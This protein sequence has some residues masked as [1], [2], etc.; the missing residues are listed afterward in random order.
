MTLLTEISGC[1]VFERLVTLSEARI[2]DSSSTEALID[3]ERGAMEYT[4]GV[5]VTADS[6]FVRVWKGAKDIRCDFRGCFSK[7][8][9]RISE[10]T[11]LISFLKRRLTKFVSFFLFSFLSFF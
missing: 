6:L 5:A 7:T 3:W 9:K 1:K 11:V 2:R 4:I 10:G 8:S